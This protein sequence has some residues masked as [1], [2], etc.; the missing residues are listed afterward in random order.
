MIKTIKEKKNTLVFKGLR[1]PAETAI[2]ISR[3]YAKYLKKT[4]QTAKEFPEADM[5]RHI[6]QEGSKVVEVEIDHMD[7]E[8]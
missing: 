6:L 8:D 1:I 4:G 5:L 2:N 3:V 7:Y